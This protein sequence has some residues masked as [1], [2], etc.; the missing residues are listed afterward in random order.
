VQASPVYSAEYNRYHILACQPIAGA[1]GNGI[2]GYFTARLFW[3][4]RAF[5]ALDLSVT[6]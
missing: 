3:N 4:G 6:L 5:L 2:L 1:K